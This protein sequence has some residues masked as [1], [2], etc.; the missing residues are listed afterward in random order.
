MKQGGHGMS[1]KNK[2]S[3]EE[4]VE[5]FDREMRAALLEAS[6]KMRAEKGYQLITEEDVADIDTLSK[7]KSL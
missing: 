2:E 7:L 6:N 1:D 5:R 4:L 3:E